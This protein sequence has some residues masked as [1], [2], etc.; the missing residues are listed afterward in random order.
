[1]E[2]EFASFNTIN[3]L[4][5]KLYERMPLSME[6]ANALNN[7][8][9]T[10]INNMKEKELQFDYQNTID[11]YI[12]Y[13]EEKEVLETITSR[14]SRQLSEYRNVIK[15]REYKIQGLTKLNEEK[16]LKQVPNNINTTGAVVTV[17]IIEVTLLLGMLLGIVA[18]VKR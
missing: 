14:E 10:G 7:F 9:N 13:L 8:I 3:N 18:L 6:E 2:E 5:A 15:R 11:V 16:T 12:V 1:M 17:V 4:I